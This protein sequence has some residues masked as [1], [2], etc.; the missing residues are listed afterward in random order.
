MIIDS[1]ELLVNKKEMKLMFETQQRCHKLFNLLQCDFYEIINKSYR[2][3]FGLVVLKEFYIHLDMSIKK[4]Y[5]NVQEVFKFL[6]YHF[7]KFC[8]KC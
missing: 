6:Q 2:L 8:K 1:S 5:D 7:N 3:N 4:Q